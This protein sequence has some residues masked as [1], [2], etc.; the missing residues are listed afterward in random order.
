MIFELSS[1]N[2]SRAIRKV[3][4]F[5]SLIILLMTLILSYNSEVYLLISFALSLT[6]VAFFS[7]GFVKKQNIKKIVLDS[8]KLEILYNNQSIVV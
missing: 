7:Y 3:V 5:L 8:N 2:R 6:L 4:K 1:A